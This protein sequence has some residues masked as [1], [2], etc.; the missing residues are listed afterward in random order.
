MLRILNPPQTDTSTNKERQTYKDTNSRNHNLCDILAKQFSAGPAKDLMVVLEDKEDLRVR[1]RRL[2]EIFMNASELATNLW[3][4]KSFLRCD[5]L[6]E[7]QGRRFQ[8]GS[9][10]MEASLLHKLDDEEDPRLN[11]RPISIVVHP[12]ILAIGTHDGENY[13]RNRPRV[14]AKAVVWVER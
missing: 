10:L 5:G 3:T 12:A 9:P 11:G 8:N 7:L 6:Q 14:L 1:Q 4:Q 13:D 2:R